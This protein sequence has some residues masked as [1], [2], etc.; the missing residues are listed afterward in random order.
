MF[1]YHIPIPQ[2]PRFT[3]GSRAAGAPFGVSYSMA[4][5]DSDRRRA[6]HVSMNAWEPSIGRAT[7]RLCAEPPQGDRFFQCQR[8]S[9]GAFM[10]FSGIV[11]CMA[12]AMARKRSYVLT[13]KNRNCQLLTVVEQFWVHASTLGFPWVSTCL[14]ILDFRLFQ[15]LSASCVLPMLDEVLVGF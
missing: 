1:F 6:V 5:I 13:G 2:G 8:S 14:G 12:L 11:F 3:S 7:P 9:K 10:W 4:A 15:E